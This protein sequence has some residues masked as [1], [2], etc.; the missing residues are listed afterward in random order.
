MGKLTA[1]FVENSKTKP[2]R[3][4]DG[5]GLYLLVKPTGARSWVLRVQVDGQRRDIGLGSVETG[6]LLLRSDIGDDIPLEERRRLTLAEA[7]ELSTRLRN[8]AKAGRSIDAE[9]KRNRKAPPTFKDAA[10]AYHAAQSHNWGAKTAAAFL[11]SIEAHA[12][13]LL[14]EKR[15]DSITAADIAGALGLVWT[16][17]PATAKK[18]RFRIN[19]VLDF[20][21]ANEWRPTEAPRQQ[22]RTLTGKLRKGK[23]HPSMPYADVPDFYAKLGEGQ[24]TLGRLGLMLLIATG[25]R[26]IEVRE[27]RWRH[28]D[29]DRK[30]WTRPAELM[31]KTNLEHM[32][33]LN[34]AALAV[35]AKARAL[36]PPK[37]A[38]ALVLPNRKGGLISDMTISK[39]MR[40][41]ALPWVPHGFRSSLRTWAA[42]CQP[43][44]PEA[45]GEAALAHVIPDA[46]VKAYNRATFVQLRRE[47][48]GYWSDYITGKE[49]N[50]VRLADRRA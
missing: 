25:A 9:R 21:A 43:Q 37:D 28:I 5:E 4:A 38:D 10:I 46:V 17:K 45:V 22:V 26:S 41:A 8:A 29:L 14:G 19:S 30:E 15:V 35:L 32:V 48:L 42:E 16:T 40:D 12:Y 33:T 20:A 7:R 31:R 1:K 27:A 3:H 11:S 6:S 23:N 47:L 44:I 18:L 50:V 34:D 36:H 24:E 13:P 2:G 49:S 39:V